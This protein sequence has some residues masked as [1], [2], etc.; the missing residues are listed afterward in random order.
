MH[1]KAW[2]GKIEN[3]RTRDRLKE[4]ITNRL[5]DLETD[6]TF[7]MFGTLENCWKDDWE[8]VFC[9]FDS[10][11]FLI[12]SSSVQSNQHE[13]VN[14][15]V[16]FP[17]FWFVLSCFS[18]PIIFFAYVPLLVLTK[19]ED[20]EKCVVARSCLSVKVYSWWYVV[21]FSIDPRGG[22]WIYSVV[23]EKLKIVDNHC[24]IRFSTGKH[25]IDNIWCEVVN[26]DA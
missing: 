8:V 19:D 14:F 18:L 6:R 15:F 12:S 23:A 16:L 1:W 20:R 10:F 22:K 26:L 5:V 25:I 13:S 17:L 11:I 21:H 9:D 24:L 2:R 4:R 3:K 7:K